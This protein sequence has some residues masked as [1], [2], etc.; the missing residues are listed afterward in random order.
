M[1]LWTPLQSNQS[2]PLRSVTPLYG[3]STDADPLVLMDEVTVTGASEEHLTMLSA[4]DVFVQ[5][6]R[7]YQPSTYCGKQFASLPVKFRQLSDSTEHWTRIS[8]GVIPLTRLRI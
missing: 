2:I 3:F 5:H 7:L 4:E 1:A 8:G 6:I